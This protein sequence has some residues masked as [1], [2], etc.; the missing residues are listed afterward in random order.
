[1]AALVCLFGITAKSS[2][3]GVLQSALQGFFA[4]LFLHRLG[5][6]VFAFAYVFA[7]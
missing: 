2:K 5:A 7:L 4:S 6:F 3:A 1:V